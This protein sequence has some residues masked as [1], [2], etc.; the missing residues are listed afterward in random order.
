MPFKY[1][2]YPQQRLVVSTGV[3]HVTWEEI[4]DRQDQTK[5]DPDFNP[6]LKQI[7]DLRACAR[8]ET[9]ACPLSSWRPVTSGAARDNQPTR[10]VLVES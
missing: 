6:D 4:Q 9:Q 1:V 2:V 5:T 3:D 10:W 7:V 8:R